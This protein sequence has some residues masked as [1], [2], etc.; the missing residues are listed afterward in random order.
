MGN[1]P[2][3]SITN[4]LKSDPT[5]PPPSNADITFVN[6]NK[7]RTFNIKKDS[8]RLQKGK[9]LKANLA[10]TLGGQ[11]NHKDAVKLPPQEDL[12]EWV[13]I[14]TFIFYEV[15]VNIYKTCEDVCTKESCPAMTAG[16]KV[17]YLWADGKKV[18]KPI[19]LSA[20]EY[21]EKLFDW[22]FEQMSDP[23]VFPP[24]DQTKFPKHFM[25]IMKTIF[26]KL[27]RLYAHIFYSHFES[28]QNKGAEAHLN[29]SFKHLVYFILE[30]DLVETA[31]LVPLK[32][33][34]KKLTDRDM[35][36]IAE[37]SPQGDE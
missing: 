21:V 30:F 16:K 2:S 7:Q 31:E 35:G 32:D 8:S 19:E 11:I 1:T 25:K 29:S 14:N 34:I 15:A 6:R 24:D 4:E 33:L 28:I 27:F 22:I 3:D 17:T 13:A 5:P 20:P 26:K 36:P 18:K 37:N 23:S 12:N 9:T 10:A